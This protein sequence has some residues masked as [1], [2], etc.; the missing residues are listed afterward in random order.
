MK[1][2]IWHLSF[3]DQG[4]VWGSHITTLTFSTG[5]TKSVTRR[6][7][8]L[9]SKIRMWWGLGLDFGGF[10]CLFC[11]WNMK[12]HNIFIYISLISFEKQCSYWEVIWIW[13]QLQLQYSYLNKQRPEIKLAFHIFWMINDLEHYFPGVLSTKHRL[14]WHRCF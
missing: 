8:C 5:L 12:S 7:W 2:I 1:R 11:L 10:V 6:Q 9:L 14:F 3:S 4:L 13:L